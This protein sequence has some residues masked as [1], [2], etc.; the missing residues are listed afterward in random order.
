[1]ELHKANLEAQNQAIAVASSHPTASTTNAGLLPA[2]VVP[3]YPHQLKPMPIQGNTVITTNTVNGGVMSTSTSATGCTH[4]DQAL[5]AAAQFQQL[6]LGYLL[7]PALYTQGA[8]AL[9]QD[10]FVATG[11]VV[12]QPQTLTYHV[13]PKLKAPPGLIAVSSGRGTDKF[14]PY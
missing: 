8:A 7:N 4:S 2:T 12:Q 11:P 13:T 10:P 1:M 6:P 5:M 14:S 3:L 9:A